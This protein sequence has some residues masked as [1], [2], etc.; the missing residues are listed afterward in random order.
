M[1]RCHEANSPLL[2]PPS[3]ERGET[4]AAMLP[5]TMYT[6]RLQ[7]S[8]CSV[9]GGDLRAPQ[10]RSN[11]L[12]VYGTSQGGD[13]PCS[14]TSAVQIVTGPS[15]GLGVRN[16][17]CVEA[18]GRFVVTSR[19]KNSRRSWVRVVCVPRVPWQCRCLKCNRKRD[20][21]G[22]LDGVKQHP[23]L[24]RTASFS[25]HKREGIPLTS[26]ALSY[27]PLF[28]AGPR[29]RLSGVFSFGSPLPG[30]AAVAAP[31]RGC[32]GG[33]ARAEGAG[34]SC[35]AR[36]P[37]HPAPTGAAASGSYRRGHRGAVQA[38]CFLQVACFYLQPLPLF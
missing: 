30:V 16:P 35:C 19:G 8:F 34:A 6:V 24:P 27:F 3:R 28:L 10:S 7:P 20:C 38:F 33:S 32:A 13:L 2:L 22:G 31:R 17:G 23:K 12:C 26:W 4:R 11:A 25:E 29:P 9:C 15:D 1:G 5:G 18:G 37:K 36:M 14:E 21:G